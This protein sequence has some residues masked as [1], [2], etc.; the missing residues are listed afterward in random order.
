M[1]Q[2]EMKDLQ[3]IHHC[4][5]IEFAHIDM[6][7]KI[8]QG[9]YIKDILGK[10]VMSE[11]KSLATTVDSSLKLFKPNKISMETMQSY[12]YQELI[13]SLSSSYLVTCAKHNWTYAVNNLSQFNSC[14]DMEHWT[15]SKTVIRYLRGTIDSGITLPKT[16]DDLAGLVTLMLIRVYVL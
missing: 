14:Y 1:S 11:S 16:N 3:E 5:G 13:G 2:F 15:A 12:T 10:L 8:A 9:R 6:K 7:I 4:V